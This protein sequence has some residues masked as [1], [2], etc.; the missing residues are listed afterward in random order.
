VTLG[1][2]IF[3][4]PFKQGLAR[5][6]ALERDQPLLNEPWQ[7]RLDIQ[8]Y[9]RVG[10]IRKRALIEL[11]R[12]ESCRSKDDD[13]LLDAV[14]ASVHDNFLDLLGKLPGFLHSKRYEKCDG[15]TLGRDL[16]LRKRRCSRKVG[17]GSPVHVL[18]SLAEFERVN[19]LI[20]LFR[21]DELDGGRID[22]SSQTKVGVIG[23]LAELSMK[24]LQGTLIDVEVALQRLIDICLRQ[25]DDLVIILQSEFEAGLVVVANFFHDEDDESLVYFG[26]VELGKRS[27]CVLK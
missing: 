14:R 4:N 1:S 11:E 10:E 17:I 21:I 16:P 20:S 7:V 5:T 18:S 12:D 8:K 22:L 26:A 2:Q 6:S 3:T 23:M 24:A 9:G 19:G 15:P 13:E 27:G 25:C